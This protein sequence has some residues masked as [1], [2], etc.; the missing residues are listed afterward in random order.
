[1]I[2]LCIYHYPKEPTPFRNS[3]VERTLEEILCQPRSAYFSNVLK[4]FQFTFL[5][6]EGNCTGQVNAA[7][8]MSPE[9]AELRTFDSPDM[10]VLRVLIP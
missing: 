2:K 6:E 1:M 10:I 3:D 5:N 8:L 7:L 9:F 4:Y